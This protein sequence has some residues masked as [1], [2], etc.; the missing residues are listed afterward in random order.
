MPT[1]AG[2][3]D[4]GRSSSEPQR[5]TRRGCRRCS[6]SPPHPPARGHTKGATLADRARRAWPG[7]RPQPQR[8]IRGDP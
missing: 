5:L 6:G 4:V 2:P 1:P 8:F 7:V 3:A